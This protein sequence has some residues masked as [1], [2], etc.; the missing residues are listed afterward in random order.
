VLQRSL[1]D[2][3]LINNAAAGMPNFR[4]S[5]L[6]LATR[7]AQ[8]PHADELYGM[9]CGQLYIEAIPLR[10][11]A[12]AWERKFLSQWLENP[13]RTSPTTSAS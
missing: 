1:G 12:A 9:R 13:T 2:R 6:R 3:V 11:D 7:I 8:S 5:R 10:Y 4:G